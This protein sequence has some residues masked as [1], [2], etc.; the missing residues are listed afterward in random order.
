MKGFIEVTWTDGQ[1]FFVSVDC[2]LSVLDY[3]TYSFIALGVK[4]QTKKVTTQFG[5]YVAETYDEVVAK[6]KEATE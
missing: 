6:I 3:G 4:K 1:K 2:I 5:Y